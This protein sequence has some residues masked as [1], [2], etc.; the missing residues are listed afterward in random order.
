MGFD[1]SVNG[2]TLNVLRIP[3]I[4][5]SLKELKHIFQASTVNTK[6]NTEHLLTHLLGTR[7]YKC[8]RTKC[9]GHH[10]K[11][12]VFLPPGCFFLRQ[13]LHPW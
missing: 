12:A 9:C 1:G 2:N 6:T 8:R 13:S 3:K 10:L 5:H 11:T 4:G 7:E